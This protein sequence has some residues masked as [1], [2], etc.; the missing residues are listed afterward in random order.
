[1]YRQEPVVSTG[2]R[3]LVQQS[4]GSAGATAPNDMPCEVVRRTGGILSRAVG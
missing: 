3:V 4:H 2:K 1:V